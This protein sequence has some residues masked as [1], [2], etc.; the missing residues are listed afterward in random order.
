MIHLDDLV[1][2]YIDDARPAQRRFGGREISSLKM[3]VPVKMIARFGDAQKPVDGF[4]SLMCLRFFIV[5]SERRRVCDEHV[6]R[7]PVF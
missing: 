6:Q 7:A 2:K 3:G 4:Q 1:G 5:D